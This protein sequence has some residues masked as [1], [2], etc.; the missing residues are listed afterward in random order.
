MDI[1][2]KKK[3]RVLAEEI[4][5]ETLKIIHARGFGHVGGSVD[6]AELMAVLYGDV[7]KFNPKDPRWPD[8][9]WLVLSKGHAG[10]VAYATFG[11]MG[12]YPVEEA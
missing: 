2:K 7:M 1:S 8:R 10:P 6:L 4:R 5:L 11:I 3:L 9:D 12:Y